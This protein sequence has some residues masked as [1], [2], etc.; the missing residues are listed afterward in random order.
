MTKPHSFFI[1]CLVRLH[2][3]I[4]VKG[5]NSVGNQLHYIQLVSGL[6]DSQQ[7]PVIQ[8]DISVM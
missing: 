3:F 8:S 2:A 6:S 1:A 4:K 7:S 5:K